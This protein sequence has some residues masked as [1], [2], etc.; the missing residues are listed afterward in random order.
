MNKQVR[1]VVMHWLYVQEVP[2]VNILIGF[3]PA[4]LNYLK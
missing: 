2:S 4:F 1:S 3:P